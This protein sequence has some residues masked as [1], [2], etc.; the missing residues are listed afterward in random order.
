MCGTAQQRLQ[1]RP[2]STAAPP[3]GQHP[4]RHPPQDR[5]RR[6]H[7]RAGQPSR[8]PAQRGMAWRARRGGGT[9]QRLGA[10][11]LSCQPLLLSDHAAT[12]R[13][14]ARQPGPPSLPPAAV[15]SLPIYGRSHSG[16]GDAMLLSCMEQAGATQL[17]SWDEGFAHAP[18]IL[19]RAPAPGHSA[20][21]VVGLELELPSP[22][23]AYLCVVTP[24]A[25]ASSRSGA[26][27]ILGQLTWFGQ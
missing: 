3:T 5:P 8:H 17:Y 15:S 20:G 16:F 19:C 13:P 24:Q 10:S 12:A 1:R 26:G 27:C 9:P 14:P 22:S 2:A 7:R 25:D 6:G 11:L 21:T 23:D 4:Q 18:G